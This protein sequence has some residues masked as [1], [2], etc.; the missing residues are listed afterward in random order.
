MNTAITNLAWV[1]NTNEIL[2]NISSLG[3]KN[4]ECVLTKIGNWDQLNDDMIKEFKGNLNG[5]GLTAYSIQSLFY[6][7]GITSLHDVPEVLKHFDKLIN[8][9]KLLGVKILVLGSPTL[10]KKTNFYQEPLS[11]VL[12]EID[13]LLEGTGMTLVIEPNSYKYGAEYFNNVSSIVEYLAYYDFN[14]IS[15][16]IDTHNLL[17]EKKD[18]RLEFINNVNYI[19]HIHVSEIDLKPFVITN[20][21][22]LFAETLKT[23]GYS[24]VITYEAKPHDNLIETIDNF[25]KIYGN[26]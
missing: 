22:I 21:H 2:N 13:K 4:I 10:R 20:E 3:I 17:L 7:T 23:V 18:I 8:Y 14:N 11:F 6:N 1:E 19:K 15:T 25:L 24:G 5:F 9:G 12:K 26:E 16:M